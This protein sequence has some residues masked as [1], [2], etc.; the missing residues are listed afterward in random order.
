MNHEIPNLNDLDKDACFSHFEDGLT[1]QEHA[2]LAK[3]VIKTD[4]VYDSFGDLEKIK[5]DAAEFFEKLGNSPATAYKQAEIVDRLVKKAIAG[6]GSEAAWITI[7]ASLPTDEFDT[8]RWHMDSWFFKEKEEQ[9]KAVFTL[10]GSTTLLYRADQDQREQINEIELA[11]MDPMESRKRRMAILDASKAETT[12]AG[13]FTVMAASNAA[14][15]IDHATVH[16]EPPI[17]EPRIFLSVLPGTKAEIAE[18]K[19]RWGRKTE[20]K[21][22]DQK[23]APKIKP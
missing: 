15:N 17:H 4:G 9:L 12:P 14:G 19:A 8:P 10:K 6:F 1:E 23:P 5:K 16:S 21:L 13:C 7:R 11:T 20:I 18:L 2:T 22:A 3:I